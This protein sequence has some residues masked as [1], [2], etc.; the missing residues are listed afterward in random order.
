M[1]SYI[2][3]PLYYIAL[4]LF[5]CQVIVLYYFT[6]ASN[7]QLRPAS[8]ATQRCHRSFIAA[9]NSKSSIAV[10][11]QLPASCATAWMARH[12]QDYDTRHDITILWADG[13]AQSRQEA[14]LAAGLRA[15]PSNR[16]RDT[17]ELKYALRAL[18]NMPW[19]RGK[20]WLIADEL[21]AWLNTA[22]PRLRL[23]NSTALMAHVPPSRLAGHAMPPVPNW[24][25]FALEAALAWLPGLSSVFF[26]WNDDYLLGKPITRELFIRSPAA[27]A[28]TT[29]TWLES[30]QIIEP[31]AGSR[32]A[33]GFWGVLQ[34]TAGATRAAA[35][36]HCS[37]CTLP[38]VSQTKHAPYV[39]QRE[40]MQALWDSLPRQLASTVAHQVRKVNDFVIV[41]AHQYWC[42]FVGMCPR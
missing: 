40:V 6:S 1:R 8:P 16:D 14:R 28:P 36:A 23:V 42:Q 15:V 25:T 38:P 27:S 18:R 29:L 31:S 39:L 19:W 13:S 41:L 22:H 11:L 12:S 24:N 20:L 34:R 32:F 35:A 3:H 7:S 37:G 21:P 9:S 17:G 26:H 30:Q 4:L 33:A 5:L 10:P 2:K